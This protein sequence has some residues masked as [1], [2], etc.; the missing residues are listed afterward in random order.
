MR[1]DGVAI[2]D[3]PVP[4]VDARIAAA[5]ACIVPGPGGEARI[6]LTERPDYAGFHAGEISFPGGRAEP[7]DGGDPVATALREA[8]EEVGLDADA[9][10]LEIVARLETVWIA[11]SSFLVTPI[12]AIASRPWKLVPDPREV[13][14][15]LEPR[16]EAFLPDAPHAIVERTIRG[17]PLRYGA[18]PVEGR[19]VWGATAK[20]LAQLGGLLARG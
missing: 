17:W 4:G 18:F 14:A 7:G 10:G 6:L 9:A 16:L 2:P 15:I 11:P 5:L 19:M 3:R 20:M 13:V 1:T 8:S 12:V